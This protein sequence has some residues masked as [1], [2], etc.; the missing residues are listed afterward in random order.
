M[1]HP[2]AAALPA[3]PLRLVRTTRPTGLDHRDLQT[4]TRAMKPFKREARLRVCSNPCTFMTGMS[5]VSGLCTVQGTRPTLTATVQ[6]YSPPF[7]PNAPQLTA[8]AMPCGAQD[9]TPSSKSRL[10]DT[11]AL[12]VITPQT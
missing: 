3:L 7:K 9:I 2:N 6:A 4:V 5:D 10:T 8:R 11:L 12:L 1:T